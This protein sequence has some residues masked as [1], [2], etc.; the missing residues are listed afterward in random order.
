MTLNGFV[1]IKGHSEGVA[2]AFLDLISTTN[3]RSGRYSLLVTKNLRFLA[4]LRLYLFWHHSSVA[5][6]DS[7]LFFLKN[8]AKGA[9]WGRR[10]PGGAV[11]HHLSK[12]WGGG[13]I[14]PSLP[15]R[16]LMLNWISLPR[17]QCQTHFGQILVGCLSVLHRGWSQLVWLCQSHFGGHILVRMGH[18]N[19]AKMFHQ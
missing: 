16:E 15:G 4:N 10:K 18:I 19:D 13:C 17:W 6:H 7:G 8:C 11:C 9:R 14:N 1:E 2:E 12:T 5:G 3:T